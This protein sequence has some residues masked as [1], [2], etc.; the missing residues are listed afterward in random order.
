M[1]FR[2]RFVPY[3]RGR[4]QRLGVPA[5]ERVQ[6]ACQSRA[7]MGTANQRRFEHSLANEDVEELDA[8]RL[9]DFAESVWF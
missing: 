3:M 6:Q 1:R 5:F 8:A 7:V 4:Q 9:R 2:T